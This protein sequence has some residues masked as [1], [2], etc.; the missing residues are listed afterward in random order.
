ML[1]YLKTV[2]LGDGEME[3]WQM[4]FSTLLVF[5][6]SEAQ[7]QLQKKVTTFPTQTGTSRWHQHQKR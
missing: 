3:K 5:Q 6:T 4:V 1:S 2:S 7:R